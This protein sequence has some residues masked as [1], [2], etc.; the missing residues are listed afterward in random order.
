M[1]PLPSH[2]TSTE[3]EPILVEKKVERVTFGDWNVMESE[4]SNGNMY[5]YCI[6]AKKF[7]L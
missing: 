1:L 7:G 5:M 2:V 3:A 4:V 6:V